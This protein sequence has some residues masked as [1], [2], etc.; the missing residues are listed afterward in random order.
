MTHYVLLKHG[1]EVVFETEKMTVYELGNVQYIKW[2][3]GRDLV[4]KK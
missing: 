4:V 2:T 1:W 3:N